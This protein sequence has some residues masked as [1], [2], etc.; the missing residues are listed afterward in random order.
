[1]SASFAGFL[2]AVAL[3][4]MVPGPDFA[5]ILRYATRST[6]A[7]RAAATGVI[8]GLCVHMSAAVLGLSALL[9]SSATAFTVVKM[10]GAAYLLVLG[11]QALW[12]SRAPRGHE[13]SPEQAVATAPEVRLR[14]AFLQG[15]LTNVLNPKAALFFLSLLPQFLDR[16]SPA[17]SQTLLLGVVTVAFGVTWWMAFVSLAGRIR[18]ILGRPRVRC[19]LDRVT[20]VFFVALGIRLVATRPS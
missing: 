18:T 2:I 12:S 20:G 16:S 3:A 19:A 9:A 8:A 4:Y 13:T 6:L 11:A 1:M 17:L 5:I 10:V 7:G 14:R 15:F